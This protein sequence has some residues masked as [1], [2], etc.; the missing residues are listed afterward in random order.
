MIRFVVQI[1]R[2]ANIESEHLIDAVVV[3]SN[4]DT[5][6]EY[7]DS[8]RMI[9]PRSAIKSL[10]ALPIFH[11]RANEKFKLDQQEISLACASHT[12]Q[13]E[14]AQKVSAWLEKMGLSEKDLECGSHPPYDESTRNKMIT[15]STLPSQVYNNCSGKHAGMLA[16]TLQLQ[17]GTKGYVKTNHPTQQL[18]LSTLKEICGLDN[19]DYSFGIDGCSIPTFYLPMS[20]LALGMA[21]LASGFSSPL[22]QPESCLQIFQS[23][24]NEPIFMSGQGE[25]CCEIMKALNRKALVKVGAEGVMAAAIPELEMGIMLKSR[26][27]QGRAASYA[28]SVL[29]EEIGLLPKKSKFTQIEIENRKGFMTGK[30]S[31]TFL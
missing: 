15:N 3:T 7:G 26:D 27:G 29:L 30:I 17:A 2:G 6:L 13:K 4:Q 14:H 12:G 10:Q 21:R 19:T 5:I 8:R 28:M 22:I 9:Y 1:F 16:V 25:Y 24:V 23:C 18:V 31:H 20:A 11:T